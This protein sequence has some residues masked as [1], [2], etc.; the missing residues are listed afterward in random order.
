MESILE[1]F[2]NEG[3]LHHAYLIT[4]D[5]T[6]NIAKLRSTI[7]KIIGSDI[8]AYSDYHLHFTP[9]FTIDDSRDLIEKQNTKSFGGGKRFFVL[10]SYSF[11]NI[12]Q[13]GLLK[14]LEDPIAD[15]HFFILTTTGE[16]LLPTLR[17]RLLH[18]EG[19]E[20]NYN[21]IEGWC[22]SFIKADITNRLVMV[23]KLLKE[24]KEE[25]DKQAKQKVKDIFSQIEKVF[26]DN[27]KDNGAGQTKNAEFLSELIRMKCY[28]NDTAPALRLILEYIA[29][30]CPEKL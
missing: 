22:N 21:S 24:Y 15:N 13:N 9:A 12:A 29:F 28:L 5:I 19:A 23:E 27:I 2:K 6:E 10:A 3:S 14:V 17:G 25:D 4:G 8:D 20:L 1:T 26:A 11:N 30:T 16:T 18:V 7:E